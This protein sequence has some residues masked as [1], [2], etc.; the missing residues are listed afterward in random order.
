MCLQNKIT[1]NK[2]N[3][4]TNWIMVH[5]HQMIVIIKK[6]HLKVETCN[7]GCMWNTSTNL[8]QE[9]QQS[10]T[11]MGSSGLWRNAEMNIRINKRRWTNIRVNMSSTR[12]ENNAHS[13]KHFNKTISFG[14]T[15]RQS[16]CESKSKSRCASKVVLKTTISGTQKRSS[17]QTSFW[18]G[19]WRTLYTTEIR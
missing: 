18:P 17:M 2:H 12:Q 15:A 3:K 16:S 14:S 1:K 13:I 5:E 4:T 6:I 9:E 19:F 10:N 7:K 11:E 8:D